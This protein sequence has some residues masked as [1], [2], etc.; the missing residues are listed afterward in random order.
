MIERHLNMGQEELRMGETLGSYLKLKRGRS[1]KKLNSSLSS[2][3]LHS[4]H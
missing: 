2:E 1:D 4:T 3:H